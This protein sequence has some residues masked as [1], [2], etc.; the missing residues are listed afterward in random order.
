MTGGGIDSA[1]CSAPA[2]THLLLPTAALP[3][4]QR[5]E[6]AAKEG[7][8]L[9]LFWRRQYVPTEGKF[10]D[11]P[12]EMQLGTRLPEVRVALRL[13]HLHLLGLL[14]GLQLLG[15]VLLVLLVLPG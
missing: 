3:C 6:E 10:C 4:L 9:Q 8:P 1:S 5:N 12:A 7:A 13:L 2:S 15:L 11:P 14:V